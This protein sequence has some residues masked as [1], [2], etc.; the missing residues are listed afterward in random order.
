MRSSWNTLAMA[1]WFL[2]VWL[3]PE[4]VDI[5]C[6]KLLEHARLHKG[7]ESEVRS[8]L[9]CPSC[10]FLSER[11]WNAVKYLRRHYN[12]CEELPIP[13]FAV[14]QQLA[15][16][17]GRSI[18]LVKCE[19]L[20]HTAAC[21]MNVKKVCLYQDSLFWKRNCDRPTPW[22]MDAR[23]APFDTFK[24]ITFLDSAPRSSDTKMIL[25]WCLVRLVTMILRYR[26]TKR[27]VLIPY[28]WHNNLV[29]VIK[30]PKAKAVSQID[31][32]WRHGSTVCNISLT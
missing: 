26:W 5:L 14:L 17:L 18:I 22:H 9:G 11:L 21:L 19:T 27:H 29:R 13:F 10:E 2:R 15:L 7:L 30:D 28:G 24:M 31:K 20:V 23:M 32:A 25:H 1:M 4:V 16:H 6:P 8:C 3:D 12:M